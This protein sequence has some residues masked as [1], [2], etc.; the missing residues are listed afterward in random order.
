MFGIKRLRLINLVNV[1]ERLASQNNDLMDRFMS[2]DFET[3][4][5]SRETTNVAEL[6]VPEIDLAAQESSVG[7]ILSDEDLGQ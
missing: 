4:V 2:T 3:Y 6:N 1:D 7:E 5:M